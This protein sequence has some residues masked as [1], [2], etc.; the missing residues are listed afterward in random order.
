MPADQHA[1]HERHPHV[2][3]L[4]P[5]DR[6]MRLASGQQIGPVHVAYEVYGELN[7]A[8]DNAVFVCHALTGDSHVTRHHADDTPGWWEHMVGPGRPVDTDHHLVICANVLG[9]CAGSEG[10]RSAGPDGRPYGPDFPRIAVADMVSAHRALLARL[11]V[12]RLRAV[13]GG[14][15]GGMQALEWL[16]RHPRDADGFLIVAATSRQ[17]ADNLAWNAIAR[18]A[19]RNDAEFRDGGYD[20]GDG[21]GAGLGTARMVAHLTYLSERSLERKFGRQPRREGTRLHPSPLVQGDFS[22]ESYLEHQAEKFLRRFDA[23]SYLRLIDAMDRFD[24]FAVAD[25]LALAEP[26]PEVLLHSFEHD[27]LFGPAHSDRIQAELAVRGLAA[28]HEVDHSC[29]VGHDAFLLDVPPFLDTARDFLDR[30][31]DTGR[32]ADAGALLSR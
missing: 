31:G 9:G 22:V 8:R 21:P 14:S 4:Y 1:P 29:D 7:E 3:E 25:R 16:L 26:P 6:P 5:S 15:L 11:G 28:R 24:A 30:L 23:H 19:I 27:R 12:D 13:V 17:S 20:P 10:P 32:R 18:F 2:A